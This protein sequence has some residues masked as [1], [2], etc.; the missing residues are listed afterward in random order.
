MRTIEQTAKN[1]FDV[2]D[3]KQKQ[4]YITADTWKLVEQRQKLHTEGK[5][6]EVTKLTKKIKKQ[7]LKI[8]ASTRNGAWKKGRKCGKNGRE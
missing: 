1:I 5:E 6:E 3:Q 7:R 4:S 2:I 8:E